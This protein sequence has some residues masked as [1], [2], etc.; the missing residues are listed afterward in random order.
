MG[1]KRNCDCGTSEEYRWINSLKGI[2]ILGVIL[3][4]SGAGSLGGIIGKISQYGSTFTQAFFVISAFLTW[5][6]LSKFSYSMSIKEALS[7]TYAKIL[8]LLPAYYIG[9][10]LYI[11]LLGGNKYWAGDMDIVSIFNICVHLIFLHGL[12]PKCCNNILGVEWYIGV[13]ALFYIVAP[14]LF[15]LINNIQK[16]VIFFVAVNIINNL[17]SHF[18]MN[19]Y[20]NNEYQYIYDSY[21]ESYGFIS[22]LPTLSLGIV[23]FF[24]LK[25]GFS[26]M[27]RKIGMIF[28]GFSCIF[29]LLLLKTYGIISLINPVFSITV[30]T[31]YGIVFLIY[32]LGQ[33]AYMI[34]IV[35]GIFFEV[36]GKHSYEM[37]IFHYL[38]IYIIFDMLLKNREMTIV[39]WGIEYFI[40][41]GTTLFLSIIIHKWKYK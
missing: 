19:Y 40:A 14:F 25:I 15:K 4:H 18:G 16:A 6:S 1:N 11:V 10:F 8:K 28:S 37:Y 38:V 32:M 30:P 3:I 34:P 2:S 24:L 17:V 5:K 13:L 27:S 41:F 35:N 31:L 23:L 39:L 12:F 9:I 26:R 22:Q 29:A 20:H 36:V 7:W 21:F 33:S